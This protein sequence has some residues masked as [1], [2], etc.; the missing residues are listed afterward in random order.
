MLVLS[1]RIGEEIVIADKIRVRIVA[2]RGDQVRIGVTAPP[3]VRV[4]REEIRARRVT[5]PLLV[6]GNYEPAGPFPET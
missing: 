1:R 5:E 3:S 2:I 4:D 6:Q